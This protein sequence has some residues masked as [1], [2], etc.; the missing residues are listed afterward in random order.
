MNKCKKNA[1]IS[2]VIPVYNGE[3]F[4]KECIKSIINQDYSNLE[5]IIIDD[6]STDNSKNIIEEFLKKDSRVK[7]YYKNNSGVSESRNFGIKNANGDFITFVDADDYLNKDFISY[8]YR[9]ILDYN[10]DIALTPMPRKFNSNSQ[11]LDE[12]KLNDEVKIVTGE[13]ASCDM[14][15]YK[16]AIGPWNKLISMKLIKE[17]NLEFNPRLSFG[18]GFKFSID[19]FQR[20]QKIAVG[21]K[22]VYNYRLDNPNSVMTKFSLKL[23]TGSIESQK[24]IKKNIINPTKRIIDACEY[25]LWHTYYDCYNTMLGCR[26]KKNYKE[27]YNDIK[28][29][30]KK[31][32]L[33]AL[34]APIN[35]KEKLK[36]ILYFI[37]PYITAKTINHF[38][39]RKFT[40]I[41]N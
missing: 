8:Y 10:A 35:K 3:K 15:Y 22:H 34:R 9:M 1:L 29:Q 5:I 26:V 33:C 4:L 40:I 32:A 19:C 30:C 13:D 16:I 37:N 25:A 31:R 20:A 28:K 38:R 41:D 11:E 12:S 23:V 24:E 21:K 36:G 2:I 6:G 18:E 39:I 7:Y 14:L 27:I 17:N